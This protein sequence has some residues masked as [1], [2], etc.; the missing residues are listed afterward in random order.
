MKNPVTCPCG[1]T[2]NYN[3]CCGQFLSGSLPE[4]AE[5]LMRSRYTAFNMLEEKYLLGT[6]HAATRPK[7][8]GLG[9]QEQPQW[10][11]LRVIN[12]STEGDQAIVEFI[13]R[14]KINGKAHKVHEISRFVKEQSR[15]FYVDG[16]NIG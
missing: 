14:Y 2:T 11:D 13:A 15:W 3:A 9:Q 6:W 8:L 4:T 5:Q 16:D 10:F 7:S 1:S 12:H